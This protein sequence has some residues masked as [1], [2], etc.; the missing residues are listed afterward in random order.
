MFE[1]RYFGLYEALVPVFA[2]HLY[3]IKSPS[4]S[5]FGLIGA[6]GF[7]QGVADDH[8][9]ASGSHKTP[10]HG[11]DD[12]AA[13]VEGGHQDLRQQNAPPQYSEVFAVGSA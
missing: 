6:S 9:S 3:E 10:R 2:L 7:D 1:F 12:R 4:L 11:R 5:L 13:S 8:G